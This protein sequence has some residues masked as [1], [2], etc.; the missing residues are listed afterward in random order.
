MTAFTWVAITAF[1]AV[2]WLTPHVYQPLLWLPY[3]LLLPLGIRFKNRR[4]QEIR[5]EES[6]R[7][8]TKAEDI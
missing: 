5:R 7:Q 1:L 4:Q 8:P 6:G 2:L 3:L